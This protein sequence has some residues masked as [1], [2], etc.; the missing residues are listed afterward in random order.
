MSFYFWVCASLAYFLGLFV[1]LMYSIYGSSSDSD[2]RVRKL[3]IQKLIGYPIIIMICWTIVMF[4][5]NYSFAYP[6]NPMSSSYEFEVFYMVLPT[7]QGLMTGVLFL[8]QYIKKRMNPAITPQNTLAVSP[9]PRNAPNATG[10]NAPVAIGIQMHLSGICDPKQLIQQDKDFGAKRNAN[11]DN[12]VLKND[13]IYEN[14]VKGSSSADKK[15]KE[16]SHAGLRADG[17]DP[18]AMEDG[19]MGGEFGPRPDPFALMR[20]DDFLVLDESR[21]RK[22]FNSLESAIPSRQ[23]R[24]YDSNGMQAKE[25]QYL[26]IDEL[27]DDPIYHSPGYN[28]GACVNGIASEGYV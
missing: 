3:L 6:N 17:S 14:I 12:Y 28:D 18:G 4:H 2:V 20:T 19:S 13:D 15:S 10:V 11:C 26:E 7:I 1:Y 22:H 9:L 16:V 21:Q 5:D 23:F 8:Y 24:P 27:R 25:G